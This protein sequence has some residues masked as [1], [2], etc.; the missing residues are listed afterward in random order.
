MRI[1]QHR[2]VGGLALSAATGA[3]L[4]VIKGVVKIAYMRKCPVAGA[5]DFSVE[6]FYNGSKYSLGFRRFR[7]NTPSSVVTDFLCTVKIIKI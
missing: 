6:T 1:D 3:S 2:P 5:V 7:A 4:G